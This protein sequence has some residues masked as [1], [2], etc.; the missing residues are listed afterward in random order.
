MTVQAVLDY[1]FSKS[2]NSLIW[3]QSTVFKYSF[4]IHP[5]YMLSFPMRPH[6]GSCSNEAGFLTSHFQLFSTP[7]TIAHQVLCPGILQART[8][9][10]VAIPFSRGSS[11]PRY[12]TQV[13][14]TAGRFFTI[15]ATR[16]ALPNE[17]QTATL[18][19][20]PSRAMLLVVVDIHQCT[21]V[22]P[23]AWLGAHS[24][25]EAKRHWG[26]W[27]GTGSGVGLAW[28]QIPTP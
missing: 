3:K 19:S 27:W 23:K 6:S 28:N 9:E 24:F 22:S 11:P 16:E 13:F 26:R 18:T 20:R 8:L 15:W 1:I 14:C 25:Q 4:R 7:W 10:W 2:T 5:T 17:D 12:Q 21:G